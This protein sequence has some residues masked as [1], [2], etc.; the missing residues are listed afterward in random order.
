M[1]GLI[2]PDNSEKS[3]DKCVISVYKS[4]LAVDDL[5]SKLVDKPMLQHEASRKI[6]INLSGGLQNKNHPHQ[7]KQRHQCA[8]S[9]HHIG[10]KV[11]PVIPIKKYSQ[12]QIKHI[13]EPA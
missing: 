4:S 7:E 11:T 1:M 2:T 9:P 3:V 10:Q 6:F 5:Y 8:N 13:E 12:K